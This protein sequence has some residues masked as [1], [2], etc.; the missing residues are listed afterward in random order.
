MSFDDASEFFI[1]YSDTSISEK[2]ISE[3]YHDSFE[4]T[5]FLKANLNIFVKDVNYALLDGDMLFINEYDIHQL[6]YNPNP[7]YVRFVITHRFRRKFF[8]SSRSGNLFGFLSPHRTVRALLRHT[9]LHFIIYFIVSIYE[10][11]LTYILAGLIGILAS[12]LLLKSSQL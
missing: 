4:V 12:I 5:F 8:G 2:I 10:Y 7:H 11:I 3:H 1:V 6:V 9:A